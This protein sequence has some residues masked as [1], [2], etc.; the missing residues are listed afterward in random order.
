MDKNPHAFCPEISIPRSQTFVFRT[1]PLTCPYLDGEIESRLAVDLTGPDASERYDLLSQAGFRRTG[2]FAYRPDCPGCSACVSVRILAD[3]FQPARSHRRICKLNA[4]LAAL[5][6]PASA[7]SEQFWLFRRYQLARHQDGDMATM[8]FSD[9]RA[10]VEE[11][12][13]ET[14]LVEFRKPDGRLVL[15]GLTDWLRDGPSAVYSFFDPKE[16]RRSLG[17]FL[18]LWLI[19]EARK[20]HLPHVYLGYWIAECRKMTYKTRFR[21][22]ERFGPDGWQ[23]LDL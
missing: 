7:T 19:E 5:E 2:R 16:N 20:R 3:A 18:I 21:P 17:S 8:D 14:R 6:E 12:L 9:Y 13:P 4:D 22:L 1:P 10:I 15:V 23:A 11:G